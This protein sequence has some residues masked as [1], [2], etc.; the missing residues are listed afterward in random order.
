MLRKRNRRLSSSENLTDEEVMVV[1]NELSQMNTMDF[2]P[3]RVPR[4]IECEENHIYFYCPV[5]DREALELNRL[6][7]RL[8]IEM[9]YLQNRLGCGEVP[10]HLHIHSPG[11]SVF[12]GLAIY[13]AI[14]SSSTPVY[15]YVEG[16]AASAATLIACAGEKGHRHMGK[17]SFML[18]HQPH[19]EWSG[20][21]DD[22]RDEVENQKELYDRL[23]KI[24]LENTNFK[25]KELTELL[26][27]ELWLNPEKCLEKGL[28]DKVI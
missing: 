1:A 22:F 4:G 12:S 17:S 28:V 9:K 25:K 19:L 24:Y 16:S 5:G 15:T 8:D 14:K 6:I 7:R 10:I 20:K 27:H 2:G 26:E 3:D 23:I 18:V 11:G 13:D 21:L